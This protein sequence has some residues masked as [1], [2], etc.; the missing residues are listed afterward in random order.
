[1]AAEVA[2]S[3]YRNLSSQQFFAVAAAQ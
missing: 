3:V 1:V 2:G